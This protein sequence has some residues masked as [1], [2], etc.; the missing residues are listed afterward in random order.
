MLRSWC[1]YEGWL[2]SLC[3]AVVFAPGDGPEVA[4]GQPIGSHEVGIG[5]KG[6]TGTCTDKP[7][8][9]RKNWNL[10]LFP[11]KSKLE[12]VSPFRRSWWPFST[13]LHTYQA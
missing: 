10:C 3:K 13:E 8:F 1:S 11:T 7:E 5:N 2:G 9:L 12:D 6:N 4:I